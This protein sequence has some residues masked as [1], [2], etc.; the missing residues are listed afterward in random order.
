MGPTTPESPHSS[1]PTLDL[2]PTRP[3]RSTSRFLA[4]SLAACTVICQRL[5]SMCTL[6]SQQCRPLTGPPRVRHSSEG[7]RSVRILLGILLHWWYRGPVGDCLGQPPV[8]LRA[9]VG[10]LLQAKLWLQWRSHGLRIR[11]L[12]E[13][14]HCLRV[15]VPI[16]C[17]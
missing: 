1:C 15:V 2:S 9:A 8:A 14:Q 10:G 16:H 5:V 3:T 6:A 12:R 11:F 4:T 17:S 7:S 13:D